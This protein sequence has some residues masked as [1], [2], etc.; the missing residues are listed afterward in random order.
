MS[1]CTTSQLERRWKLAH[2]LHL[3]AAV[4]ARGLMFPPSDRVCIGHLQL[5]LSAARI[6]II[7]GVATLSLASA[8]QGPGLNTPYLCR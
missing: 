2:Y 8:V 4:V 5:V 3:N 7:E 1:V 6:C